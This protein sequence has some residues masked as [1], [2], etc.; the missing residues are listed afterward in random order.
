MSVPFVAYPGLAC[1]GEAWYR[2]TS[3]DNGRAEQSGRYHDCLTN[4]TCSCCVGQCWLRTELTERI[5]GKVHLTLTRIDRLL[6]SHKTT[7]ADGYVS[8]GQTPGFVIRGGCGGRSSGRSPT[9]SN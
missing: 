4:E 8:C 7:T 3:M 9:P 5:G 1:F 2:R 6:L